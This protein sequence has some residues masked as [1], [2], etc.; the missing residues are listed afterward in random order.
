MKKI[1][2]LRSILD[3]FEELMSRAAMAG[4]DLRTLMVDDKPKQS[5]TKPKQSYT[6]KVRGTRASD[7]ESVQEVVMG[8]LTTHA[9]RKKMARTDLRRH[10]LRQRLSPYQVGQALWRLD[11]QKKIT[12]DGDLITIS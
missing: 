8:I 9:A 5:S 3:D 2:E 4:L 7:K 1:V 6:K 11:R 12:V 10:A